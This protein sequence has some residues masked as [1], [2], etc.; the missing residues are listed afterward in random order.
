MLGDR[1]DHLGIQTA[2]GWGDDR[3]SGPQGRPTVGTVPPEGTEVKRGPLTIVVETGHRSPR[4]AGVNP[5]TP[6]APVDLGTGSG[7]T[8]VG[9]ATQGLSSSKVILVILHGVT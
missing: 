4:L 8:G 1:T 6:V 3:S 5:S 2:D 7:E 9:R